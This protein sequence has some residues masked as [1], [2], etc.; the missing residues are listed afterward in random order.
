MDLTGKLKRVETSS[1]IYI[2]KTV[3]IATGA[4]PRELGLAK[5]KELIGHGVA[6]CASCDGM[7]YKIRSWWLLVVEILLYQ[8][9]FF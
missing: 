2:G 4:N 6:Y 7:F 8:M 3:V 9:L 1:G 5:E